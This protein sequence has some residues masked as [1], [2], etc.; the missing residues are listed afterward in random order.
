MAERLLKAGADPNKKDRNG[1]CALGMAKDPGWLR[2]A[3]LLIRYNA[4]PNLKDM[5]HVHDSSNF[6]IIGKPG[7]Y[8]YM[9]ILFP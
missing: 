2:M 3:E 1:S 4:D 9:G 5:N 6:T 7:C 8:L